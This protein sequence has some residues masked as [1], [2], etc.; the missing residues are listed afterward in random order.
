MAI[1]YTQLT[2]DVQ[3]YCENDETDFVASIP[4]FVKQAEDR[5]LNAVEG[6]P[7]FR[8]SQ[9]GT[10]TA[11]NPYLSLPTDH[12]TPFSLAVD[13]SGYEYLL[14]KD[15]SFI[16]EVYGSESSTGVPKYYAVFSED[17]YILGPT[18]DSGYAVELH[19]LY[20]P[21]SI[22]DSETSWLGNNAEACLLYGTLVEAYTFMKGDADVMGMYVTRYTEALDA[23]KTL[24]EGYGQTD[25]YRGKT[26]RTGRG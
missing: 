22:V 16:R 19:Y 3:L 4:R 26:P 8:K 23:L 1:T 11:S 10:T 20:R 17:S 25:Q 21:A 15:V 18:P 2:A 7:D 9:T 5:I 14:L 13:N 12:L 6:L 24:A